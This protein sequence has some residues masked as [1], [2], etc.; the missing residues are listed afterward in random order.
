VSFAQPTSAHEGPRPELRID[1]PGNSDGAEPISDAWAAYWHKCVA[2]ASDADILLFVDMPGENQC[3]ALA[4][5]GAALA[6]GR[7][8]FLVSENRWAPFRVRKFMTLEDAAGA[9]MARQSGEAAAREKRDT[10]RRLRPG[11]D[12]SQN[13]G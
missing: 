10:A 4:E 6:L 11:G 12:G 5:M 8:V 2:E 13:P 3:G 9:L 1:W 7:Q